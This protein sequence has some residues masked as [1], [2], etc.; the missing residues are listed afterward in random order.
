M[1][2]ALL[3]LVALFASGQTAPSDDYQISGV[4]IDNLSKRPLNRVLVQLAKAGKNTGEVTVFT[5]P[6]G[7]FRFTH[8]PR[9]RYRL[10]AAKRGGMLEAF[11]AYDGYSTAI[12]V[13]GVQKT[14][15]LVFPIRTPASI[16]GTVIDE[17]GDPVRNASIDLFEESVVRG[18]IETRMRAGGFST[19]SSGQFHVG[20]L[21]PGRY[22]LAVQATPWF[23]EGMNSGN[24]VVFSL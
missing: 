24:E 18:E 10:L 3:L 2:I 14:D 16:S 17:N 6:A 21:E 12:V 7:L 11:Q 22:Y 23:S 20:H 13:D 1:R 4:V 9:G 15:S 19:N 5:G 8:V